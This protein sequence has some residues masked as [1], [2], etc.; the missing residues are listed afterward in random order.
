MLYAICASS[1]KCEWHILRY[2]R[3]YGPQKNTNI[4]L[5]TASDNRILNDTAVDEM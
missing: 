4:W 1:I 3:F 2:G 5:S